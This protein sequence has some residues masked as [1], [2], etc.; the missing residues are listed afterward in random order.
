MQIRF[1]FIILILSGLRVY[2]QPAE[3]T[4]LG[5]V[6]KTGFAND[7][8]F[9]PF[10]IGFN[11]TYFGQSHSQFYVNT[12]GS[13]SFGGGST[14]NSED[15]IP[16]ASDP[17]NL[18]AAFWDD[19]VIDPSGNILYTTIGAAPNRKLIVQF[20][21]MGFWVGPVYLG[22]FSVILYETSNK[23]KVQYRTLILPSSTLTHGGSAAIGIENSDGSAGVQYSYHNPAAV[24]SSQAIEFTP[25]G[26]TYNM[27]PNSVYDGVYLTTNMTLPEPGIINL[28]SPADNAIIGINQTFQWS[29]APYAANYQLRISTS[30]N[31]SGASVYDAGSALSYAI[32]GLIADITYYWGVFAS[33]A[34]GT[35]WCEIRKFTTSS[36]PPLVA[37]PQTSWAEQNRDTTL[38]LNYTGGDASAKTAIITTLPAQGQLYQY[39]AGIRGPAIT[40]VPST[41]TDPER[42]VI[43]AAPSSSGNGIGN[44][45]FRIHDASGDSPEALVTVNVSPFGIPNVLYVSKSTASVEIQFDIPMADPAGKH[46]Q[47]GVSVN[48]APAT[49]SSAAL[50]AG[51]LYTIVLTLPT[52]LAGTE[53]VLVNYTQG[54]VTSSTGGVLLSFTDQTVSL[55]S[56]TISF[57]Q[58]LTKRMDQSPLTL[59]ATASSSLALT[60]SSS[61][62][63]VATIA[64]NVATL[65]SVGTS[66]ITAR[67]AGNAT[68]APAKFKKTLTVSKGNQVITFNALPPKQE[69]DADFNPGATSSSGLAVSYSSDNTSVATIV[70]G[71][72]H[73]INDGTAIITA[74]HP[75]NSN[76]F[77]AADVQQ[78]LVVSIFTGVEDPVLRPKSFRIYSG[79]NTIFIETLDASWDGKQG[80]VRVFDMIGN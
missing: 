27:D 10:N 6:I 42:N 70:G 76:Y 13:V 53:T 61:D 37:V 47:F 79:M 36:M 7:D 8:S 65:R 72:I 43:Y 58:S 34:T 26:L 71:M 62:L 33:N 21:N 78:E 68:Y 9:G 73:I 55:I 46:E 1:F 32:E 29:A 38:K 5:T 24:N 41:V 63:F 3:T 19:I 35:T 80:S 66:D 54:D 59:N 57:T 60:Y 4:Y 25:A 44:F 67:Q 15:P 39:N 45:N 28:L 75:G 74:S 23:I 69:G 16:E 20:R 64:G 2:S 18:I 52:P 40:T 51:D 22:T 14:D 17:D 30:P 77:P 48:S 11:F 50:K 56:Q 12:N 49:L 31:L